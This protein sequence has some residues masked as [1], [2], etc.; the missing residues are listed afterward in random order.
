MARASP[1][2][3]MPRRPKRNRPEA[4][5]NSNVHARSSAAHQAA[6]IRHQLLLEAAVVDGEIVAQRIARDGLGMDYWG[7]NM[8]LVVGAAVEL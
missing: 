1:M 4:V 3:V 5:L 2:S 8:N 6:A 7:R